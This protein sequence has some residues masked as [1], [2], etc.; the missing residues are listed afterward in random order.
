MPLSAYT[1]NTVTGRCVPPKHP[2]SPPTSPTPNNSNN[3]KPRGSNECTLGQHQ[4][5]PPFLCFLPKENGPGDGTF[6]AAPPATPSRRFFLPT[7]RP[8][9]SLSSGD[10]PG[11][12]YRIK[13][14][15]AAVAETPFFKQIPLCPQRRRKRVPSSYPACGGQPL[16]CITPST[17]GPCKRG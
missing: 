16:G 10:A 5:N 12:N 6:S 1:T 15:H 3:V 2:V 7:S 14:P 9:L 11:P 4:N 17:H 13:G 8:T